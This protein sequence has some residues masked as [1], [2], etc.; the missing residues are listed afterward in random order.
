MS[1]AQLNN[2]QGLSAAAAKT[3]AATENMYR[4]QKH[5]EELSAHPASVMPQIGGDTLPNPPQDNKMRVLDRM[6]RLVVD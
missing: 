3:Q 4:F 1:T 2:K 5:Q 6:A